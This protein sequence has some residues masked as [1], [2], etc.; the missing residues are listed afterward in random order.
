MLWICRKVVDLSKSCGFVEKLWICCGFVEKLWICC[1]FVEKSSKSCEFVVDLSKSCGFVVDL[2]KSC[3]FVVDLLW[4]CC[5][6][7]TANPQQIEQVEFELYTVPR[8]QRVTNPEP[9]DMMIHSHLTYDQVRAHV[10]G[11][12]GGY[13]L[14]YVPVTA[15]LLMVLTE[16]EILT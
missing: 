6:T 3:G 14:T 4:I 5:T 13:Q 9:T 10:R 2:S 12:A 8:C 15:M 11:L 7:C 16:R 1:G